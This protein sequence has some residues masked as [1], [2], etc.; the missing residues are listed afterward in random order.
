MS[1]SDVETGDPRVRPSQIAKGQKFWRW[2]VIRHA[3]PV[4]RERRRGQLIFCRRVVV[5]C[6]CGWERLAWETDVATGRSNGCPKAGC[7]KR[8]DD[9]V[10]TRLEDDIGGIAERLRTAHVAGSLR[11]AHEQLLREI[12][13]LRRIEAEVAEVAEQVRLRSRR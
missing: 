7:R 4:Q 6:V 1:L 8:Y 2:T 3:T 13:N 9:M 10:M 11:R 12:A 5:R